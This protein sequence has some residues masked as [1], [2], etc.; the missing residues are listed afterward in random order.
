F[1]VISHGQTVEVLGTEFNISAYA[2]EENMQTTLI[3]GT[4]RVT[5]EGKDAATLRPGQQATVDEDAIRVAQVD[6]GEYTAWKEGYFYFNGDSP[7]RAFSQLSRWYDIQVV[8]RGD[9]PTLAFYGKIERD[10]SLQSLLT[11]LKKAGLEFEV[12]Q[13]TNGY[14]LVV[15]SE[16]ITN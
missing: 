13:N 11:I 10:K 9:I 7:Q 12:A 14:Q 5:P 16:S 2:D 3:K 4:V 1:K 15:G 8:Y 6:V